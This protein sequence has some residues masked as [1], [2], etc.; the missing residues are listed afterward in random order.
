VTVDGAPSLKLVKARLDG[1]L[2]RL[3]WWAAALL[4][5]GGWGWMGFE[6][7]AHLS[8]SMIL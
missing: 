6:V 2:G 8:H 1:V 4:M 5:A 7:S 3:S